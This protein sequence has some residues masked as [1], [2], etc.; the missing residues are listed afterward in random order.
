MYGEKEKRILESMHQLE[1]IESLPVVRHIHKS[2]E[3]QVKLTDVVVLSI[4]GSVAQLV[5]HQTENLGV[6]GSIPPRATIMYIIVLIIE[7]LSPSRKGATSFPQ[8]R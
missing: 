5:E 8:C 3:E 4:Y 2:N 6:G 7:M 1:V